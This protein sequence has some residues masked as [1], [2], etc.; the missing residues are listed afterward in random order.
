MYFFK[1]R[2][3]T[4]VNG[5]LIKTSGTTICIL[6][7][8]GRLEHK[9][10]VIG[11]CTVDGRMVVSIAGDS[12]LRVWDRNRAHVSPQQELHSPFSP[13]TIIR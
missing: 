13:F 7:E 11:A 10:D 12:N 8:S 4:R 5:I 1:E 3:Y 6:Q 9:K 2:R